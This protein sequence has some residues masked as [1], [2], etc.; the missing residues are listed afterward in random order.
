MTSAPA[1]NTRAS[2]AASSL[3]GPVVAMIFVFLMGER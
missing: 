1:S 3:F 2:V